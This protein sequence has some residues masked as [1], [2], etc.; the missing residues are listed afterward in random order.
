[1]VNVLGASQEK[2]EPMHAILRKTAKLEVTHD[3]YII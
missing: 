2:L 3:S 1:M